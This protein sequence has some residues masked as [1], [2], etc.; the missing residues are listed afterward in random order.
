[1]KKRFLTAIKNSIK[2][3]YPNYTEEKIDE[4]MYGVEGIYLTIT[5]T[6]IIFILAL[7]LGIFKEL[8]FLLIS[9]N[10]IRLFSFGMH[11]DKSSI[12]LIFSSSLFIGGTYLCK[13]VNLNDEVLYLLYIIAF[14]IISMYSPSDTVKRPLIK[15]KK[16]IKFKILSIL[17]TLT[18]FIIS[19]LVKNSL[20]TNSLIFGLLIECILI[21]PTTYKIFKMP[22]N[23][24]KTY[25]LNTKK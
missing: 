9:F 23:N 3:Q 20:I 10:F 7:L 19:L 8:I 18:Y 5:K 22:Y 24:Y 17:V 14:I 13:Y 1:M 6:I 21:L 2:K 16:R 4:I 12:C 11:A 25:G 15:K